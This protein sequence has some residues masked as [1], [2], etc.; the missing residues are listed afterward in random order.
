[1]IETDQTIYVQDLKQ[2]HHNTLVFGKDIRDMNWS[3]YQQTNQPYDFE[4]HLTNEHHHCYRLHYDK[5]NINDMIPLVKH[6]EYFQPI[7]NELYKSY[8]Q[9]DQTTLKTLF[10]IEKNGLKTYE[11]FVYSEYNPYTSTG[12]PSNRFGGMN[13]SIKQIRRK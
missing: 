5:S 4:Q 12:R 3:W 8:E 7:S 2:Y 11:K 1:M 6:A 10:K 13:F 9:Y